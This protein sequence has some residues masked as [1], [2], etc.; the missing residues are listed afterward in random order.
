MFSI[1][2]S[3]L[4]KT[5]SNVPYFF[6][7]ALEARGLK[8]NRVNLEDKVLFRQLYKYSVYLLIKT[9][10][11]KS[12]HNYF[13]S[14]LNHWLTQKKIKKAIQHYPNSQANVFLSYSFSSKRLSALPCILFG[15]WTYLYLIQQLEQRKPYWFER[16][17]LKREKQHIQEADHVL[18]LFPKS[19]EYISKHL[20]PFPVHYL[21]NVVNAEEIQDEGS[22]LTSKLQF[23][24][25]LFIGGEKYQAAARNLLQAFIELDIPE[26][27][28]AELHF[29]GLTAG[30]FGSVNHKGVFFHGYLDKTVASQSALYYSLLGSAR[31]IINTQNTWGAFSALTEAMYYYTPVICQAFEEFRATYGDNCDFGYYV[32]DNTVPSLTAAL[33]K[34]F[35]QSDELRITQMKTAHHK[36]KEFT[37]ENYSQR[38]LELV[39][40]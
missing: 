13:R 20:S 9:L 26:S 27:A 15:D 6:T 24:R 32:P 5:W 38:F 25:L 7:K 39:A 31:C 16:V 2:D 21:G 30:E 36:T 22:I 28:D 12:T 4:A 29:I 8:V 23:K 17:A 19:S 18:S 34:L 10:Y 1:G 33:K 37:W 40:K 3:N 35:T 11:P 14:G